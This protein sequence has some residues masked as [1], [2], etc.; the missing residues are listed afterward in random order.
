MRCVETMTSIAVK[1]QI[2]IKKPLLRYIQEFRSDSFASSFIVTHQSCDTLKF[3][4]MDF[5]FL[6]SRLS[7]KPMKNLSEVN[8]TFMVDTL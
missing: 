7:V 5:T 4:R 8:E 1:Q 6:T 3:T 2:F